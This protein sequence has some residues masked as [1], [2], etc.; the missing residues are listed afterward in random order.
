MHS[1]LIKSNRMH[2]FMLKE[3]RNVGIFWNAGNAGIS[4]PGHLVHHHLHWWERQYPDPC[5]EDDA[6]DCHQSC[7]RASVR[8][9]SFCLRSFW[10]ASLRT[11][12]FDLDA[13]WKFH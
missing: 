9:L 4:T 7:L 5:H 8:F 3:F 6:E 11:R 12:T 2:C 1:I 10:D 13:S